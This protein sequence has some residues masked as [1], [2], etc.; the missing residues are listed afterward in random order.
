[1]YM[2]K[3]HLQIFTIDKVSASQLLIE[4]LKKL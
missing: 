2:T 3:K 1:M 4:L